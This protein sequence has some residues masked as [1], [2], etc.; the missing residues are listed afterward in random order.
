MT[1][2]FE[3][4]N[5]NNSEPEPA[6]DKKLATAFSPV[7]AAL[8]GLI[9]VFIL[10][11]FGGAILTILILGFDFEKADVN[12]LRL[13]TTAGQILFILLPALI[14][15]KY[16]YPDVTS[17]LRVKLP[18][19]KEIGLFTLGLVIL[20]PLLQSF[21][22]IQNFIF[23][24]LA[25]NVAFFGT[26]KRVLDEL[27]KLVESAYG[28]LL[29]AHSFFEA[30]F[31][32]FVVAVVPAVCEETFFRGFVQKSFEQ[33]YSPFIAIIFTSLFFGLYHFN[34]YGLISLV[35]L[36]AYFG[37]AAYKSNSIFVP[38][39]LHFINNFLSVMAFFAIGDKELLSSS[40]GKTENIYLYII[41]FVVLSAV[42]SFFIYHIKRKYDL[43]GG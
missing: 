40:T 26:T 24:I 20:T 5:Q 8:L 37:Y 39:S 36:G 28:S 6:G 4:N 21:L 25:D 1:D 33:K 30:S 38:I 42:F 19:L 11:Q 12:A 2:D 3:N 10:Y 43:K 18:K 31:I 16:V 7:G 32:V 9:T 41:S 13:L 23:D 22:Y 14:F 17:A 34:P 35:A 29:N 15:A 27:D